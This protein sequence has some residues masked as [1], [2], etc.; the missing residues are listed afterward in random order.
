MKKIQFDKLV[1]LLIEDKWDETTVL[2][3]GVNFVYDDKKLKEKAT[4]ITYEQSQEILS[5][6]TK[7]ESGDYSPEDKK[8]IREDVDKIIKETPLKEVSVYID[9]INVL[10]KIEKLLTLE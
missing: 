2:V 3:N 10:T 9:E 6:Y 4:D 1:S 5:K 8:A 7:T